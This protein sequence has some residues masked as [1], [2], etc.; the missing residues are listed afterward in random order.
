M[1][2]LRIR[3]FRNNDALVIKDW[4]KD[5]ESFYKW[6]AGIMGEYP[7]TEEKLLKLFADRDN[8]DGLFPFTALEENNIVGF[9]SL[10]RPSGDINELRFGFVIVSPEVRGRGYGKEMLKLAIKFAKEIYGAKK[11]GLGVFENNLSAFHC[12]KGVGF[13]EN[14]FVE[15]YE[16]MSEKWKCIEMTLE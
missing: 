2:N 3:P 14:G 7:L 13:V 15:E 4:C 6:C 11:L 5:E 9:F 8:N 10:R 1:T 16:I 12:Y